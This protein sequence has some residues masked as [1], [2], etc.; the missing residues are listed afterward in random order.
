MATSKTEIVIAAVDKA[1]STLNQIGGRMESML[2]PAND[3]GK[4]FGRLYQAS[5]VGGVASA[6]GGI[7][8][9]AAT[10]GAAIVGLGGAYTGALGSLLM[11]ANSS[12][13]AVGDVAD[14]AARYQ[15]SIKDIQ[16]FGSMV[17]EAGGTTED[18]ASAMGKLKKAMNDAMNGGKEQAEAFAGVGISVS[19]LKKMSADEVMLKMADAFKGS[20]NDLQKQAVLLQ[21]MGKNGTVF[22]DVMNQGSQAYKNRLEEMTADGALFTES[23]IEQEALYGQSWDR[24]MRTVNGVKISI[25]M[26]LASA[27]TPTI[28]AFQK[29]ISVNKAL[30]DQKLDG[31]LE[32]LPGLIESARKMAV[33]IYD[34][35]FSLSKV[36]GSVSSV[37]GTT[38]TAFAILAVVLSPL[39]LA[40]GQLLFALGKVLF[41]F[42]EV[43]RVI[44]VLTASFRFLWA[45]LAANPIGLLVTAV[46]GLAAAMY[47]NWDKIVAYVGNAW[48]R[49]KSTFDVGFFDGMIQIWLEQWQ[50]LANGILGMLKSVTPD[51]LMP[52]AM[53]KLQF[54]FATD[55][56]Q[57]LTS[58][59]SAA[60][61][62][63]QEI[64][65]TIKLEIDSQGRSRVVD[66]KSGSDQTTLDVSAGLYMAGA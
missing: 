6:L 66:M 11:F 65:N 17:E 16:V 58:A 5:G 63:K 54:T 35:F 12:A 42:G 21:L 51:F 20:E 57:D 1:T 22:M 33:G 34:V 23:Q 28:Q 30:I 4:A 43:T 19:A 52:D 38:G 45:L 31:F 41:V 10:A 46:V 2:K 39:I 60:Q 56:A 47:Q 62:Q 49:I 14:L 15:I 36:L 9:Q 27:L 40:S 59:A 44:P 48:D 50:G 53:K 32:A 3:L 26:R 7:A 64:K 37:L 55:R 13:N 61:A 25:G 29:W 8:Q 18:A 24:M